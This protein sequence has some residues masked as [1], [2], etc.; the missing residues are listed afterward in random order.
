MKWKAAMTKRPGSTS[1][2]R[3]TLLLVLLAVVAVAVVAFADMAYGSQTMSVVIGGKDDETGNKKYYDQ[4][5]IRLGKWNIV[6]AQVEVELLGFSIV[7]LDD[8]R[9]FPI[10]EN[11]LY[12]RDGTLKRDA[13]AFDADGKEISFYPKDFTHDDLVTLASLP[14][15]VV[16]DY[17][18]N[19]SLV[20]T[21]EWIDGV[22]RR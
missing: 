18:E 22:L 19:Q 2:R 7:R 9:P 17:D 12:F 20:A 16:Y 6:R 13:K 1:S 14:K 10:M 21:H 15:V 3:R 8:G 4:S 11:R 5:G